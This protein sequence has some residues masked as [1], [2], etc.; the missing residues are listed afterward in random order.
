LIISSRSHQFC[1]NFSV[2]S[3]LAGSIE[4]LLIKIEAKP[5]PIQAV[6]KS[7]SPMAV[8]DS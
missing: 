7:S 3:Q 4:L 2:D 5:W 8:G 1:A 6:A